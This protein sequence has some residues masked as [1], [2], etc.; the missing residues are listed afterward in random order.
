MNLIE[1]YIQHVGKHLP[2]KSRE[3][4]KRE[5]RS[6]LEDTLEDRSRELGRP[7]DEVMMVDVLKEFGRPEKMAASYTPERYLISP[8]MFPI[9]WLVVKIV[10]SVLFAITLVQL[11]I[12]LGRADANI[13]QLLIGALTSFADGSLSALG[14]I[15]LVFAILQYF[16]PE[17]GKELDTA[18]DWNPLKME[19]VEDEDR[20]SRV[21]QAFGITFS[22]VGLALFNFFPELLGFSFDRNGVWI[23]MP[24]LSQAFFNYLPWINLV[25]GA[26]IILSVFLLIQ[27]QWQT[28][29]RWVSIAINSFTV[30]LAGFMLAGPS[31][32]GLNP[33]DIATSGLGFPLEAATVMVS[34]LNQVVIFTLVLVI[35][36]DGFG[37]AKQ[38]YKFM[39][40]NA[41]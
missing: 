35:V 32:V 8:R 28:A 4:V 2:E 16:M 10:V 39:R 21:G 30:G 17:L 41:R 12:S 40:R 7:V 19:E 15:V 3:D 24:A 38:L 9:F 1:R 6:L 13:P 14:N 36:L 18:D 27:G 29:T 31:L 20:V 11:F 34:L 5:I 22:V 25:W 26:E 37:I 33:Q 23:F